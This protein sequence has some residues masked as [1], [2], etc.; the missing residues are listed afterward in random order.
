MKKIMLALFL[1]GTVASVAQATEKKVVMSSPM[2]VFE[3]GISASPGQESGEYLITCTAPEDGPGVF[4]II[5]LDENVEV[6][7]HQMEIINNHY[8]YAAKLNPGKKYNVH[9]HMNPGG[10]G[11]SMIL[12]TP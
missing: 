1:V 6:V 11:A 5:D 2:P 8:Q 10:G 3:F 4:Q 7:F 9:F 12:H